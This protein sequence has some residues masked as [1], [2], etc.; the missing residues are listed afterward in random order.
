MLFD[1]FALL[2]FPDLVAVAVGDEDD[3]VEAGHFGGEPHADGVCRFGFVELGAFDPSDEDVGGEVPGESGRHDLLSG[4]RFGVFREFSEDDGIRVGAVPV[5]GSGV[6]AVGDSAAGSERGVEHGH[7]HGVAV[8]AC[9]DVSDQRAVGCEHG[10]LFLDAVQESPVESQEVLR[11]VEGVSDDDGGGEAISGLS[12]VAD[13]AVE[14]FGGFGL[15]VLGE[16]FFEQSDALCEIP[17]FASEEEVAAHAGEES[18]HAADD[19]VRP[20]EQA[21]LRVAG[22]MGVVTDGQHFEDDEQHG[23]VDT[24]YEGDQLAHNGFRLKT[25]LTVL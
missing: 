21:G 19:L 18:V 6:F 4:L 20:G 24:A 5:D 14:P 12:E 13:V 15:A 2:E 10:H 23:D 9:D 7:G 22:R 8:R 17:V 3:L 16:L 25:N 1:L 11:P